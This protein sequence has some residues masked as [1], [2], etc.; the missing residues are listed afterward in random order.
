MLK[1]LSSMISPSGR[2]ARLLT[3]YF[4]R[5]LVKSD[6]MQPGEPTAVEFDR[7]LGWIVD[8]FNVLRPD[9]ACARLYDGT[10][11][12]AAALITFD[13]GYHDNYDVALPILQRH[14]VGATF[15]VATGFLGDGMQFN[16]RIREALRTYGAS[17]LDAAWLGLGELA[18][19]TVRDKLT[20]LDQLLSVVKY[21]S[22]EARLEAVERIEHCCG[23]DRSRRTATRRE[24]MTPDEVRLLARAGM[25]IGGHTRN[26][27]I[28]RVMP[29]ESA[30]DE[31]RAGFDDLCTIVG[32][33]PTLFSYPNGKF[34]DD[35]EA[36]HARMAR[37]AGFKYAFS[38]HRGVANRDTD[39]YQ[40]PRFMPWH[41]REY[42]FKIQ[43]LR[44]LAG[45]PVVM[46]P[47]AE[48]VSVA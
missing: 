12:S 26:H 33:P 5:V 46:A 31:I 17:S 27:P 24:M 30:L 4:H 9:E 44:L 22:L 1:A 19:G 7:T 34:G 21:K 35:Y 29:S 37:L 13:D 15:F 18:T 45:A 38:T 6:P 11:P 20:S 47:V 40:L 2:R 42:A 3:F 36:Q 43:A 25:D 32:V 16:D 23:F 8:Q 14:K 10:L 48:S 39:R 28:L 41:T